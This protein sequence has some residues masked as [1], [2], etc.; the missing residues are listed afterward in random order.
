MGKSRD[1][2]DLGSSVCLC[3]PGIYFQP[4]Y[5]FDPRHG[6]VAA[7][8]LLSCQIQRKVVFSLRNQPKVCC[9]DM[10]SRNKRSKTGNRSWQ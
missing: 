9:T 2:G 1:L 8:P 7:S 6:A 3:L 5:W 4:R 10:I